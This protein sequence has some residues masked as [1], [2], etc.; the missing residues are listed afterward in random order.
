MERD[1]F[2]SDLPGDA[3]GS[4]ALM[5]RRFAGLPCPSDDPRLELLWGAF[6]PKTVP[7][8]EFGESWVC[9][10]GYDRTEPFRFTLPA[11]Y[12][13]LDAHL[14]ATL[15]EPVLDYLQY[16]KAHDLHGEAPSV[17]QF[18]HFYQG[19]PWRSGWTQLVIDVLVHYEAINYG[20]AQGVFGWYG[21][22]PGARTLDAAAAPA[23]A[24]WIAASGGRTYVPFPND[25]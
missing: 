18:I 9:D 21:W 19:V 10:G 20:S 8:N 12:A 24:A 1:F 2:P 22:P 11:R 5:V 17:W 23:I 13:D 7:W 25:A 6:E 15:L 4:G 14:R 3:E 16:V